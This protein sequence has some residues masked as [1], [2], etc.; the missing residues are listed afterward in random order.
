MIADDTATEELAGH[1][2]Q[3]VFRDA[4]TVAEL[5]ACLTSPRGDNSRL[6]LLQAMETPIK[7]ADIE[8]L[9]I[10]SGVN[11]HHRHLNRL[12]R[13]GLT[14][15]EQPDGEQLYVRTS[16]AERAINAVRELERRLGKDAADTVYSAS[17]GANSIRLFLRIYGDRRQADWEQ[18]RIRY[19]A[20]EIGRLSL[21][22][23]RVIEG[24]SAIDKL[25]EAQ[26]LVYLDDDHIHMQ[27]AKARA[28]YQYL[29]ELYAI[30]KNEQRHLWHGN[31]A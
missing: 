19:S 22:L 27:P 2:I 11:E 12:A 9:R 10:E 30:S 18:L 21:F 16:L 29:R 3:E 7:E 26:L 13:F 5:H 28:F 14:R 1:L 6:R 23:P 24:I 8:Q 31:S 20:I 25:N 4:E 15:L 17:L